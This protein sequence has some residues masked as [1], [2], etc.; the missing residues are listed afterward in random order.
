MNGAALCEDVRA[1][2]AL[3]EH[4]TASPADAATSDWLVRR[5]GEAGLSA[6]LQRFPAPL[7][8]PAA[9]RLELDGREIEAFP[10][11]PP[12]TTDGLTAPLA[13]AD[14]GALAGK[15]AVL[16]LPYG[17]GATWAAARAGAEAAIAR[18]ALAVAAVTEGPTGGVIAFNAA[19]PGRAWDA[20]VVLVA[21]RH[22]PAL[23]A[24][25]AEG[26]PA[27][28]VLAGAH[29]PTAQAANVIARRPGRGRTV[30]VTTP[31]SGWFQ[32]AG[33]RGSGIAVFLALAETLARETD[34][35]LLFAATSGHE[36]GYA[37]GAL[38][39]ESAPPPDAVGA[40]LHI[41][42]NIALQE[43]EISEAGARP[44]G[45]PV[46]QRRLTASSEVA[47]AGARAFA[48]L[49]GYET[50]RP[51]TEATAAGELELFH[52]AGYRGLAGLLGANALFHTRLDR[53]D[54]ATT[55]EILA[56][57]ARAAADFL[58]A[59]A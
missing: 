13:P 57:V 37:G 3:G 18:G 50:P 47:A 36:L 32:C 31:K 7:F 52:A 45:R 51:L 49:A 38:F 26:Q 35:D 15:I 43:V 42:A 56:P 9:C 25:A 21:G 59:L 10:A 11:W 6:S 41:G 16:S 46:V 2:D 55:P 40:W 33:E 34:A 12:V 23:A 27:T 58:K 19:P 48:G 14:G 24:A 20:P 17:P 4:R 22:G 39:L 29:D 8:T 54:V 1:Y 28:L 44:T 53:A 5:L 30:V